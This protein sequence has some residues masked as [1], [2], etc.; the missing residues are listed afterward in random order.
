MVEGL[1]EDI[2]KDEVLV[3]QWVHLVEDNRGLKNFQGTF[4]L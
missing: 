4:G 3:K 2:K 1:K